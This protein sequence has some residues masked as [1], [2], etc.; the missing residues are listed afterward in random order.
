MHVCATSPGSNWPHLLHFLLMLLLIFTHYLSLIYLSIIFIFNLVII[1]TSRLSHRVSEA[2]ADILTWRTVDDRGA[3]KR[4]QCYSSKWLWLSAARL[5][6]VQR[7]RLSPGAS[8]PIHLSPSDCLC[9]FIFE[10]VQFCEVCVWG[11]GHSNT[12]AS[13]LLW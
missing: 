1:G 13:L 10:S 9:I 6:H 7:V 2:P 11:P 5:L 12:A 3:C 4:G 8:P